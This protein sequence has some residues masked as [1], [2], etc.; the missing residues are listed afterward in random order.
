M[1][2]KDKLVKTLKVCTEISEDVKHLMSN[3]FYYLIHDPI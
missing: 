2:R 3:L 1:R